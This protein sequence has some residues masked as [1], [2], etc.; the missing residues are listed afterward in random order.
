[1]TSWVRIC[2]VGL[3]EIIICDCGRC[4]ACG[5]GNSTDDDGTGLGEA[6]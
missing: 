2:G 4:V 1:M 6:A 3:G 5:L